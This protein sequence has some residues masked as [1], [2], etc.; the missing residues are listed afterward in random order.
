VYTVSE[1]LF[2]TNHMA[3][4]RKYTVRVHKQVFQLDAPLKIQLL[5]T[6]H[7]LNVRLKKKGSKRTIKENDILRHCLRDCLVNNKGKCLDEL[8]QNMIAR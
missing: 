4:P 3:A 5:K 1:E 7:R 8:V 6:A 2:T